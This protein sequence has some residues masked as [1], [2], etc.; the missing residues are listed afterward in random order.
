MWSYFMINT[1]QFKD[2]LRNIAT[3]KKVEYNSV[4]RFFMYDRF[5]ERLS[6]SKYRDKF[7]LKG[8]F[9]LSTLFGIDSRST[10]DIDTALQKINFSKNEILDILNEI[11]NINLNDDVIFKIS[12]I[13]D[14]LEESMYGGFRVTIIFKLKNIRDSFHL[15]IATG[16][17]IYPGPINYKYKSIFNNSCVKQKD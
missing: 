5:I 1:M 2:K 17:V 16:D 10:M 9:Y 13:K 4:L 8:G 3:N 12:N 6:R 7:I 15:D 11:I 14:I